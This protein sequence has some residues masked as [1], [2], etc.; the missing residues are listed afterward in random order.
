M[1]AAAPA[2]TQ[3]GEDRLTLVVLDRLVLTGRDVVCPEGLHETRGRGARVE[4]IRDRVGEDRRRQVVR[5]ERDDLVD[6]AVHARHG[7]RVPRGEER[8]RRGSGLRQHDRGRGEAI[9]GIVERPAQRIARQRA[10]AKSQH[11]RAS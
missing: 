8:E 7:I 5:V 6:E 4:A 2:P 10:T 3:R 11:A 1:T 9:I